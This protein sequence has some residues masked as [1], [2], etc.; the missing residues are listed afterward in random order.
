MEEEGRGAG[1][2]LKLSD[3]QSIQ[4]GHMVKHVTVS[5]QAKQEFTGQTSWRTGQNT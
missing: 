1:G 3:V 5:Y 2:T 4:H